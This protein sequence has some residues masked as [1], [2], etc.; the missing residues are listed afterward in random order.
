MVA[1]VA[2][3]LNTKKGNLSKLEF[4]TIQI[5]NKYGQSFNRLQRTGYYH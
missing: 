2:K 5:N 1:K 3:Q 4:Y